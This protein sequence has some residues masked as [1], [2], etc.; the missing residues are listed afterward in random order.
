MLRAGKLETRVRFEQRMATQEPTLGTYTYSWAEFATVWADVQDVLPSRAE[1]VADGIALQ[2]R[3]AR[4]R[5]RYR[6]DITSDMR[7]VIGGV[8]YR[9]IAGPAELGRREGL[10]LMCE[11]LTTEGVEP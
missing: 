10:E 4:V 7:L 11:V 5:I 2:A 9:I 1:Q 6:T 3:P 8:N